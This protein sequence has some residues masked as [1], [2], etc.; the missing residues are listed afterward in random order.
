[1]TFST[2]WRPHEELTTVMSMYP[3]KIFFLILQSLRIIDET[4]HRAGGLA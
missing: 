2:T 3:L 4:D 1:M